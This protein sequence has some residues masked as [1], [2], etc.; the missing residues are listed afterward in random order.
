MSVK[1]ML[2]SR[3][4][5][6]VERYIWTGR[7]VLRQEATMSPVSF[8]YLSTEKRPQE[9]VRA[10][11][12]VVGRDRRKD[13]SKLRSDA[14]SISPATSSSSNLTRSRA[15]PV[16]NFS[17]QVVGFIVCVVVISGRA[18]GRASAGGWLDKGGASD[19]YF[20]DWLYHVSHFSVR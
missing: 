6:I 11:C 16:Q 12:A 19:L 4:F 18:D 1:G 3:T 10:I 17:F 15:P 5:A 7:L 2:A 14:S 13:S 20:L 9:G 8:T